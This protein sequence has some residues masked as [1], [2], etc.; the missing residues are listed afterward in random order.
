MGPLGGGRTN[1]MLCAQ[2][3]M[4]VLFH[5]DQS[6]TMLSMI[7]TFHYEWCAVL[8]TVSASVEH[9]LN[10]NTAEPH[11]DEVRYNELMDITKQS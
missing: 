5:N 3:L 10:Q 2:H 4:H 9:C 6:V 8:V 11:Y 7:N 1:A